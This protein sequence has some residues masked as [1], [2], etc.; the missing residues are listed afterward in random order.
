MAVSSYERELKRI[1]QGDIDTLKNITKTCD[2]ECRESYYKILNKPFIVI[3]AAGS[4]GVDLVAIRGDMSFPIEVKSSIHKKVRFSNDPRLKEQARQFK[5][6]CENTGLFPIY[7]F[8]LKRVRGDSWRMFSLDINVSLAG[9]RRK[10]YDKLP[11]VHKTKE[12]NY[13]LKW[14]EGWELHKFIEYLD[15]VL[16]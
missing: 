10:I 1:F 11:K 3:R 16:K 5:K 4:F 2:K 13:I 6:K 7:A 9:W 15:R 8:R 12:E 14:D